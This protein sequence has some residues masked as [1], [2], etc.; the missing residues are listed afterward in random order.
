MSEQ[1]VC[2]CGKVCKT[3]AGLKSHKRACDFVPELTTPQKYLSVAMAAAVAN[4]PEELAVQLAKANIAVQDY[5]L[6]AS[7]YNII[8]TECPYRDKAEL[9]SELCNQPGI[10][11][12]IWIEKEALGR[13]LFKERSPLDDALNKPHDS[14]PNVV[15]YEDAKAR[16]ATAVDAAWE[17]IKAYREQRIEE[18]FAGRPE[19]LR[20]VLFNKKAYMK[21]SRTAS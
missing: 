2:E 11:R 1:F 14:D 19:V 12:E 15:L 3:L 16:L 13:E 17:A 9:E 20:A 21:A 8:E 18:T 6:A 10:I 7:E 4:V 5:K